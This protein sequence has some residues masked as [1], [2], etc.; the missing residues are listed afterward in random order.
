MAALPPLL[1]SGFHADTPE[2][3]VMLDGG[4][5]LSMVR[6]SVI[7]CLSSSYSGIFRMT[8]LL[9]SVKDRIA[10]LAQ[11]FFPFAATVVTAI[12]T[13]MVACNQTLAIMLTHQLCG[14]L[15]PDQKRFALYLEN[16]VVV[17]A[18]LIPWSIA[19][20]VPLAAVGAPSASVLLA[21]YLYLL[22]L[23]GLLFQHKK[24]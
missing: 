6:V 2:A 4:G 12:L 7:V 14:D 20:A 22:P 18:P 24:R 16:S 11:R 10:R 17:I 1:I 9:H 3:A 21:C 5:I 15:E 23:W 19:G 13:S 8:G